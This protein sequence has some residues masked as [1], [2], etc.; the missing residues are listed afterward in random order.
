MRDVI[1]TCIGCRGKLPQKA[2]VRFTHQGGGKLHIDCSKK[3]GGRGAYVCSSQDCIR[4]AFKFPKRINSVLRVQL[5]SENIAQFEQMLL[6]RT[7]KST[8]SK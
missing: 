2:L 5:A 6:Q 7:Q 4:K 8:S 1:R 3:L